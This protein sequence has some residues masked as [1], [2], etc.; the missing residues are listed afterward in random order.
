VWFDF[1]A[2]Q[3]RLRV[4][5]SRK[6]ACSGRV[7]AERLVEAV[8]RVHGEDGVAGVSGVRQLQFVKRNLCA[9]E[10]LVALEA[11]L[12]LPQHD[13]KHPTQHVARVV[14]QLLVVHRVIAGARH[15]RLPLL[16]PPI[17]VLQVA[18]HVRV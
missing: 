5:A 8:E 15:P 16:Q 9:A 10:A 1:V 3:G 11:L 6:G 13:D 14:A 18:F 12:P 4:E 17:A 2:A 7:G